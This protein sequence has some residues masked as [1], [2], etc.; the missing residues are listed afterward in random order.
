MKGEVDVSPD[1]RVRF[2]TPM[3]RYAGISAKLIFTVAP[4]GT[5]RFR[6]PVPDRG[7]GFGSA[8]IH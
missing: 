1:P 4:A 5:V 3:R 6:R 7:G 2:T 8:L